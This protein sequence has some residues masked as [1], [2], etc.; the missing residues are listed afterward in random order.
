MSQASKEYLLLFNTITQTIERLEA[1]RN[2]L[3]FCQQRAE[4]LYI[5]NDDQDSEGYGE[6][7]PSEPTSVLQ[8]ISSVYSQK[9]E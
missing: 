2:D 6:Y 8:Q 9:T 1:L 3:I 4:E 5:A 7:S